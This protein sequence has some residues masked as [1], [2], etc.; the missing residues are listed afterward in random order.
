MIRQTKDFSM[1]S[2]KPL[3]QAGIYL[4]QTVLLMKIVKNL[5]IC[6]ITRQLHLQGPSPKILFNYH[7]MINIAKMLWFFNHLPVTI[8]EH[9][10][11][12]IWKFLDP[13]HIGSY[14][15]ISKLHRLKSEDPLWRNG[16]NRVGPL[17]LQLKIWSIAKITD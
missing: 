9:R 4:Q 5:Q 3:L 16:L 14:S 11:F 15:I 7:M 12:I 17:H 8:Q 6:P 10:I 1:Q 13:L 2:K